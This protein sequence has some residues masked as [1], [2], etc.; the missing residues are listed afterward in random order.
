MAAI[1]V[2]NIPSQEENLNLPQ[3]SI[4]K[5]DYELDDIVVSTPC[6]HVLWA[7]KV[8]KHLSYLY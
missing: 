5:K 1:D 8:I 4:C 3:C 6:D 2:E 7:S